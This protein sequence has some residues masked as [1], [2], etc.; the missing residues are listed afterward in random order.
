M[1]A[2]GHEYSSVVTEPS[3]TENGYTTYICSRCNDTYTDNYVGALG[4]SYG[5]WTTEIPATCIKEGS[6]SRI[7]SLCGEKKTESIPTINHYYTPTTIQPTC[8]SKGFTKETCIYCGVSHA[9]SYMPALGHSYGEWET[10]KEPTCTDSGTQ[11][12]MCIRCDDKQ[13]RSIPATGHNYTSSVV[14]PTCTE[15][16]YTLYNCDNCG[17]S[18]TDGV[19][20][21][22]GHSFS[23]WTTI[24]E[25]NCTEAGSKERVCSACGEKETETIEA[26]GHDYSTEWTV[27]VTPTCTTV[28]SKSHH[29]ERCDSVTESTPIPMLAHTYDNDRDADCN[30]CGAIREINDPVTENDPQIIVESKKAQAGKTVQVA[31]SMLNNPGMWGMDLVVNYDRSKL[32]LTGVTN[33]EVFS[34]SEWMPGDLSGKKYI[35]SYEANGF[36]NITSNGVLAILEFTVNENAEADSFYDISLSYRPGDIINVGFDEIDMAIVSGGIE[37]IDYIYGDL[38]GDGVVNKKDSLLLKMYLAD[39]STEI[40]ERAADVYAD[41]VINKKD[42]LYLKQY[43]AGYDVTLGE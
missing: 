34:S 25:P 9:H 43:L 37:V 22:L 4:H 10:V 17:D 23:E 7:C 12:R 31:V 40:D 27:D 35:L 1:P 28:G 6:K 8:T 36:D 26:L 2:L 19:V 5:E 21:A 20:P 38:N 3:C 24:K 14:E 11:S 32:T 13:T 41:G 16:G 18:Y 39:N 30:V 29:C 42:S 33:G 15:E